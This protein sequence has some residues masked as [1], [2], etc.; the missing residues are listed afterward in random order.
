MSPEDPE[1][2][3]SAFLLRNPLAG[4]L[5]M[6]E[7]MDFMLAPFWIIDSVSGQNT[8]TVKWVPAG[9]MAL[10]SKARRVWRL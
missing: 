8:A 3:G 5:T 9:D 10:K 4:S 2:T 1:V 7:N 6:E